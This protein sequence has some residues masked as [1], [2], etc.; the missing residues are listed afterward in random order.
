[1]RI[2]EILRTKG[3]HVVTI[4]PG[5]TVGD[6]VD[7]L[8]DN[9]IGAVVVSRGGSSVDGIVSERDIV[10]RLHDGPG[11]LDATVESI[12]TRSV[13]TASPDETVDRLMRLMTEQRIRHVPV[14]VQGRLAGLVSIGDVVKTRIN[15]LEFEREQLEHYIAGT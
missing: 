9:N 8:A 1:M 4:E 2:S 12:M 13:H 14:L 7:L 10:R 5:A 3:A 11:V 6:L 15:E